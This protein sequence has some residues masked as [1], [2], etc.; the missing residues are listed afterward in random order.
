MKTVAKVFLIIAAVGSGIGVLVYT[1]LSFSMIP[2]SLISLVG[3]CI[4]AVPLILNILT[5]KQLCKA[6]TKKEV[7]PLAIATLILGGF[8][9][10]LLVLCM[11]ESD[12]AGNSVVKTDV[13]SKEFNTNTLEKD[14]TKLKELRDNGTLTE[15]EYAEARKKAIDKSVCGK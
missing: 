2:A 12:F 6:K 3:V 14:L 7:M 13:T 1:I 5:F 15:E 10:G 4:F 9:G 11:D 8:I